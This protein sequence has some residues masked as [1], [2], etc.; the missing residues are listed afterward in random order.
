MSDTRK[1]AVVIPA[2]LGSRRFPRKVLAR[3]TG[4]YLVQHVW[5][6]VVGCPSVSRVIIATDSEEVASAVESFGGEARMTSPDHASGTDRVAEVAWTLDEEIVINVQGDEPQIAHADLERLIDLFDAEKGE[7]V[8]MTPLAVRRDDAEGFSNP[9]NVKVVMDAS[10]RALYFSR[11][12]IPFPRDEIL[13][14][15]VERTEWWHHLGLYGYRRDFVLRF[16]E[17]EPTPIETRERLE[18]LRVLENGYVIRVG[19]TSGNHIGID[20]EEEY[21]SFVEL[22]RASS[23]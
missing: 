17:L 21:R 10:K 18:Q 4:K 2:R 9:N 14:G 11:A 16:A 22:V 13:A 19:E 6:A 3:D 8:H 15:E 23:G 20:T 1:A 7:T 5:D 12:E